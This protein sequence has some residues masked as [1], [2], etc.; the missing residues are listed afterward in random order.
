MRERRAVGNDKEIA[1]NKIIRAL[2]PLW[3]TGFEFNEK[4][5]EV[6]N[7]RRNMS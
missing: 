1:E 6:F 4:P 3:L 7:Q 2:K 5:L